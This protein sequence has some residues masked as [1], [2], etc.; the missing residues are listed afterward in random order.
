MT[1]AKPAISAA[2]GC[3]AGFALAMQVDC[4]V[5]HRSQDFACTAN[6]T[7]TGQNAGRICV[8]G[9]CVLPGGVDASVP[10][11]S[12]D[13]GSGSNNC[14]SPCTSCDFSSTPTCT[15][16]CAQ[17]QA[18]KGALKCPAGFACNV[19]CDVAMACRSGVDCTAATSCNIGCTGVGT[20]HD[21][22]C[23][24]GPCDVN[25]AAGESCHT[26]SC[27]ASCACDVMCAQ[28]VTGGICQNVTCTTGQNGTC[29][30]AP[31]SCTS[32]IPGCNTCP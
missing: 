20:C 11:A 22:S 9:Y 21:V 1:A 2:L 23:G 27:G 24:S 6:N 10:D 17:T 4:S 28:A 31:P 5:T 3:I 29:S 16:D 26:V 14:P 7:C 25:C 8:D 30:V 19:A 18:C 32:M 13:A 12:I 15:I